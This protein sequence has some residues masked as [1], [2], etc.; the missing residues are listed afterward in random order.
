MK[1]LNL[2]IGIMLSVAT[3]T[4]SQNV[5]DALRYSQ[6]FYNGTA[7]FMSMGGA[8]TALGGD[9]SALSQN[10]AGLGVFRSS[11]ISITP[12]LF[13]FRSTTK[14]NGNLSQDYR[15]DFTLSQ[16]GIVLNLINNNSESGL[17]NL[18]FGYSFNRTNNLNQSIV[19]EGISENSSLADSWAF[20]S[21]AFISNGNS[22]DALEQSSKVYDAYLAYAVGVIDTM[23]GFYNS[24]KFR[25]MYYPGGDSL[26]GQ[27]IK[28]M[29]TSDGYTGEHALSIGGNISN[30]LFLG[31][32]LG[33]SKL[34]Y[35]SHYQHLEMTDKDLPSGYT[36]FI[37]NYSF[38][39]KG[40]G[41][42][43]KLGAIFK[44]IETL[45]IGVAFH[46]PTYFRINEYVQDDITAHQ[47]GVIKQKENFPTRYSYA[48]TTP[49]KVMVG[50]AYQLKKLAVISADYEFINYGSAKF[51]ETG[52]NF[53]YT[54]K[55]DTIKSTL[56]PAH[57]FRIGTEVRLGRFYF[58][59][60]Y[61]HYGKAFKRGD[62]NDN[63]DYDS[64]SAGIGFREQNVFIDFG[65]SGLINP[66]KYILY[67][68]ESDPD[69]NV[70]TAM[71]SMS[72]HRNMF[73][74]TFGYKFGY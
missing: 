53:D 70:I 28:R 35:E 27:T 66:Q 19:I 23:P 14:F 43:L 64:F 54:G 51:S 47:N 45:R 48:L 41:Y 36:D 3:G 29:I 63:I 9:L 8:F 30:K 74:V 25:T 73:A 10:P 59:G 7:R 44:P 12:Q 13:N 39:D 62:I 6:V 34:S 71:S 61:G 2:I 5:D 49:F 17:I 16:A 31:L 46:S 4:F 67:Q 68:Y 60:G 33:I 69:P 21:W 72:I 24:Y 11:E 55:N 57:N 50:G 15:Y 37:Y 18:N 65:Y 32:T 38:S 42:S 40:T 52:D 56:G 22:L 26:Y 1:K 20:N 58:R